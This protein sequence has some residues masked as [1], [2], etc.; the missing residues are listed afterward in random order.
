MKRVKITFVILLALFSAGT[1][2]AQLMIQKG[3]FAAGAHFGHFKMDSDN[4]ELLLM[5]NPINASGSITAIAPFFEYAY[6]DDRS[7]GLKFQ[8]LSGNVAIDDITIDL[9][10]EGMTFQL[11]DMSTFM[12]RYS[13][14]VYHRNYFALDKK[15]RVGLIA[16]ESLSYHRTRT[17][18][19]RENPDKKY[20][21]ANK[22]NIAFSPGLIF[23]VMNNVSASFTLSIANMSYGITRCY[24]DGALV[25]DRS[26]FDAR[27]G[28]D[29]TGVNFGI[30]FHF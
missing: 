4:S 14:Y 26:K 28:V 12:R 24:T 6:R 13:A 3:S 10:S 17:D 21:T 25:G 16:E 27:L 9:P 2:N 18:S 30:A 22:F 11:T 5:V 23:F 29:I 8:Y 20:A 19:D 7:V 1:A 15:S